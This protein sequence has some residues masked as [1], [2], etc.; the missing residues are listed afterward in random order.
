[1][2]IY[3]ITEYVL[4]YSFKYLGNFTGKHLCRSL[5]LIKLEAWDLFNFIEK[6]I[7]TEKFSCKFLLD[8]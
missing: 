1:M 2:C 6:E 5:L 7:P 3:I 4:D 8:F